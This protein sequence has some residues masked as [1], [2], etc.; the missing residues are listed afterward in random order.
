VH[1]HARILSTIDASI[2]I[3]GSTMAP[4]AD[5]TEKHIAPTH[6]HIVT[7]AAMPGSVAMAAEDGDPLVAPLQASPVGSRWQDHRNRLVVLRISAQQHIY[8]KHGLNRKVPR[9]ATEYPDS[10]H[11]EHGDSWEYFTTF[12]KSTD[13]KIEATERVRTVV[14]FRNVDGDPQGVVTEYCLTTPGQICPAWIN[15]VVG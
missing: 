1:I 12:I 7:T 9:V 8:S 4:P 13:G 5:A 10:S 15:E 2:L 11:A 6:H 3:A 14:D